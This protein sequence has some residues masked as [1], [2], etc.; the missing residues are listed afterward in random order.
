MICFRFGAAYH[1]YS[2]FKRYSFK[3]NSLAKENVHVLQSCISKLVIE[4][5]ARDTYLW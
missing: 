3:L 1:N 4:D 5:G 2:C